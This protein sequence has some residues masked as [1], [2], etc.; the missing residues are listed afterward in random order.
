MKGETRGPGRVPPR[1][2][3]EQSSTRAYS[4]N[5]VSSLAVERAIRLIKTL[6]ARE[7]EICAK[8]L[9][10]LRGTGKPEP[11]HIRILVH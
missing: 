9:D 7:D 3:P 1:H 10:Q 2:R 6:P 5:S 4:L 11:D 8:V